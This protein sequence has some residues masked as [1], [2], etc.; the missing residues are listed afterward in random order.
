MLKTKRGKDGGIFRDFIFCFG[1]SALAIF[2]LSLVSAMI[3]NMLDDPTAILGIFSLSTM[4][5]AA[6]VSG[7]FSV[8]LRREATVGYAALVALSVVLIMLLVNVIMSGGKIS[9]AA[10]MNYGCYVGTYCL[11]AILGKHIGGRKR[12]RRG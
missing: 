1:F 7:I 10:F 9:A 5:L 2:L 4:I 3:L 12:H 8:K 6:I 11:G